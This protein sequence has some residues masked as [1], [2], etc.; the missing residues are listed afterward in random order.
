MNTKIANRSAGRMQR[1]AIKSPF[2][3]RKMSN[4]RI[5]L[6][7]GDYDR[8]EALRIGAVCPEGLDVTYVAIQS[9]PEIFARMIRGR[10]FDVAEM[11]LS[12]YVTSRA[13]AN[14]PFVALPVFPVRFFRHGNI[15]INRKRGVSN[16]KHLEGKRIGT[17]GYRQTASCWIRG[18][19][20]DDHGVD[21]STVTWVEGGVETPWQGDSR[22]GGAG[23]PHQGAVERAPASSS[24]SDML[25]EGSIDALLGARRPA[26]LESSPDVALLFPDF[27]A[28][29]RD[30]FKRTGIFPIMHTIVMREDLYSENRWIAASLFKAFEE[31][32]RWANAKLRFSGTMRY[33]LPWMFQDI[34]EMDELFGGDAYPYGLEEN[35]NTLETFCRNLKVQGLLRTVP[36]IESLFAPIIGE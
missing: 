22:R 1:I 35:R 11:S 32:K 36:P 33:M 10:E 8:T 25:A 31:S 16:P 14:F 4:L 24:L 21:L 15:F 28:V 30:Y 18:L 3:E 19:L 23:R 6:A 34:D 26:S 27:R 29:E 2:G 12:T 5:S 20:M 9:P 17:F 7:C 13:E